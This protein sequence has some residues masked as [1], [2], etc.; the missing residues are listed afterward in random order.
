MK[1][2]LMSLISFLTMIVTLPTAAS[3]NDRAF[4]SKFLNYRVKKNVSTLRTAETFAKHYKKSADQMLARFIRVQFSEGKRPELAVI[5]GVE[6]FLDQGLTMEESLAK[7]SDL[8]GQMV[9]TLEGMY[10]SSRSNDKRETA[11][12]KKKLAS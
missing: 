9:S 11:S 3:E 1:R 7:I 4:I 6:A 10:N 12:V 8:T 5:Y 2:I